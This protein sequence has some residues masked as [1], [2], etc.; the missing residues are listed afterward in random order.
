MLQIELAK[1][2]SANVKKDAEAFGKRFNAIVGKFREAGTATQLIN[3]YKLYDK[4]SS[5]KLEIKEFTKGMLECKIHVNP[6]EITY[7]YGA[8]D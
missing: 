3:S 4:S 6:D 7:V 2:E 1:I 5:G 8:I